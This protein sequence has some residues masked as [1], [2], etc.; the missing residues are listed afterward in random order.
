[1][2]LARSLLL[3]LLAAVLALLFALNVVE[4]RRATLEFED[5]VAADVSLT[6]RALRP[7]FV[8]VWQQEGEGRALDVLR[9]ADRDAA[10]MEI[11][12]SPNGEKPAVLGASER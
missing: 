8:E 9:R 10:D 11:R 6:G 2:K 12:W 1:M 7:P 5:G 3:L 4:V